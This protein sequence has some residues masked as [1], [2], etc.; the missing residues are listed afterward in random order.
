MGWLQKS[1]DKNPWGK[2]PENQGPPDLEKAIKNFLGGK[3][4]KNNSGSSGNSKKPSHSGDF[5][6]PEFKW[7]VSFFIIIA[8]VIWALSGIYIVKPPEE[9]A[10]L[11]FGKYIETVQ[12]GLHW[13]PRFIE[14]IVTVNVDTVDTV[15]LDKEMLTSKENIVHVSF[16]VQYHVGDIKDYLFNTTGPKHLLSQALDSAVRQVIGQ[17]ELQNILTTSRQKITKQVRAELTALLNKYKVGIDINEVLMQPARPPEA[18]KDAFDDVIKAREDR[19][20]LQNEA[21]SYANRVVPVA[22]GQAQRVLDEAQAYKERLIL[23]ATGDIAQFNE[24]LPIYNTSPKIIESQLYFDTMQ[25]V[26]MKNKI[27]LVE[28]DGN[29]NLF[30]LEDGSMSKAQNNG[31]DKQ[32]V[33]QG[34]IPLR[35]QKS[36]TADS[37]KAPNL[38]N[39]QVQYLRWLEA[40]Q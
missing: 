1:E 36:G 8:I 26:F 35:Y 19:E 29:N 31:A 33:N 16:A 17:S 38:Q 27:F 37:D 15:T 5:N 39:K 9:A 12:P 24:L 34:G 14:D 30:Y 40:N 7:L 18:V 10:V 4:N 32:I 11:R 22:K 23:Q 25:K 2:K 20:K 13:Y 21:T 6:F 3:K 28:G